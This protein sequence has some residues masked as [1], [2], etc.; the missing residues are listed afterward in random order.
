M[1]EG[2]AV[3]AIKLIK[4]IA[5]NAIAMIA[6]KNPTDDRIEWGDLESYEPG[7]ASPRYENEAHPCCS[8]SLSEADIRRFISQDFKTENQYKIGMRVKKERGS[9]NS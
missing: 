8:D 6:K 9:S 7:L 1:I 4:L 5:S 2:I 3:R